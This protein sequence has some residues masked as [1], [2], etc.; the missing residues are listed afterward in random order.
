MNLPNDGRGSERPV[1]ALS[2]NTA[3]FIINFCG[4][5]IRGFRQSGFEPVA[6]SPAT[7]G[8]RH[9]M[10][11]LGLRHHAVAIDR[12]GVNPVADFALYRSYRR[13]L[14]E[15]RPTAYLGF[16]I[17][18]NI[19]GS[20]AAESLGI[21]S[22][23]NV[24]G[25][26]TAFI[27]DGPLQHI[28][29]RLYR[30]GF[31]SVPTVFFQN[32]EDSTL[33]VRRKIVRAEQARVLP[34]LGIDLEHFAPAPLPDEPRTFIL[35]A[36]LLRDKGVGEFVEAA[37]QLR[38]AMA[39]SRFQ[40]LGPLD[41]G[42][43]TAFSRDDLEQWIREGA[44]EYLGATDDVR[45]FIA[46]AMAVVLP[47]YREGMPRSLLEGAAMGRPLIATDVPGCRDVV[48][49][50]VNGLLCKPRDAASLRKVIAK[51]ADLGPADL[52]AMGR[53]GRAKVEA[54]FSD[55]A[56]LHAYLDVLNGL[57]ILSAPQ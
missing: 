23:P 9:A 40:L 12:S 52:E 15:L 44:I 38:S 6:I 34:G 32:S 16:T 30:K 7:D 35:I 25:L 22:L 46:A 14:G 50:G 1:V 45:P 54:Q 43:L 28:V 8:E 13:L 3:W 10:R 39:G 4:G 24:S 37:K 53:A 26:G 18:P 21:P 33:F 57:G 42:N 31:Q 47:S 17:K 51:L 11:T 55:G 2:A 27:R 56:V 49:D 5:L 41:E 48:T 20:L 29:T 19:Y 36:R